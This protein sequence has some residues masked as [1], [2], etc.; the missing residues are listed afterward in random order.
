MEPLEWIA[1][2]IAVFG[3]GAGVAYFA[4][5]DFSRTDDHES[6]GDR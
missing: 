1:V 3:G 2:M 4:M 5:K 6:E